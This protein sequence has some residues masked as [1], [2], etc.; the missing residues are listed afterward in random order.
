MRSCRKPIRNL[1]GR[2]KTDDR[3]PMLLAD[4]IARID[5]AMT[6]KEVAQFLSV[7]IVT[8]YQHAAASRLPSFKVGTSV[9]FDPVAVAKWLRAQ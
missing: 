6:A 1:S 9:R 8:I 5:H 7:A 3:P 4:R 2:D